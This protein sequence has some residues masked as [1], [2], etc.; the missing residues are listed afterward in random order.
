MNDQGVHHRQNSPHQAYH[1]FRQLAP[2][3]MESGMHN[4]RSSMTGTH[5]PRISGAP[6]PRHVRQGSIRSLQSSPRMLQSSPRLQRTGTPTSTVG[7]AA[8]SMSPPPLFDTASRGSQHTIEPHVVDNPALPSRDITNT[9][10]DDAYVKFILY[11]NP[12]VPRDVDTTELRRVFRAPPRSDGKSFSIYTLWQLIKKLENKELK[13]WSQLAI[14][15]GVEPPSTEKGQSAQ[16]IQQY[17]VRLKRWMRA[18]HIDAFFE[19][20]LGKAHRYFTDLPTAAANSSEEGRDGVPLEEDLALRALM[21]E[22]RPKR[23]RKKIEEK[24][25]E[26]NSEQPSAKRP[27]LD[28]HHSA[29]EYDG[30]GV[31][32]AIFPGSAASWTAYPDDMN[33]DAWTMAS[34]MSQGHNMPPN[35][36]PNMYSGRSGFEFTR[37]RR[38]MSPSGYPQSAI[39]LSHREPE[40]I[41]NEPQSAITPSA[42]SKPKSSRRRHGPAVSSAWPSQGNA[43]S[44]KQRGRPPAQKATQDEPLSAIP[45]DGRPNG[46]SVSTQ[47][48]HHE[49]HVIVPTVTSQAPPQQLSQSRPNKKLQLQ[50]PE[51]LGGPVRLATPPLVLVNGSGHLRRSSA[52]YFRNPEGD[53]ADD[54]ESIIVE[55]TRPS[56]TLHDNHFTIEDV[57]RSFA[58]RLLHIKVIGRPVD[59]SVEEA[60][61]V[62]NKAVLSICGDTSGAGPRYRRILAMKCAIVLGVEKEMGISSSSNADSHSHL[63]VRSVFQNADGSVSRSRKLN[64]SGTTDGTKGSYNYT[65]SIDTTNSSSTFSSS[66]LIRDIIVPAQVSSNVMEDDFSSLREQIKAL[67]E[68]P[69]SAIEPPTAINGD[70]DTTDD[71]WRQRF[72]DIRRD[73]KI[74]EEKLRRLKR[75]MLEVVMGSE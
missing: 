62:A 16:K 15:L 6:S 61:M 12:G 37:W 29:V 68:I 14:E 71:A 56:E 13:T 18:M 27:H 24:E 51:R 60:N 9:N 52:D 22:W 44:G 11:A 75:L 47:N 46:H 31:H 38:D 66:I 48:T 64:S 73:E 17:A 63:S 53:E 33:Q 35:I 36:N 5:L 19:Y 54:G 34:A 50:V 7:R 70:E 20:C 26:N 58:T 3:G 69:A 2:S 1:G 74:A 43:S 8:Y 67:S 21:P 59:L 57:A 41:I 28:S 45:A 25:S 42:S 23:G 72:L 40:P 55:Q 32:S 30:L 65:I 4:P 10:I 39:T 49:D